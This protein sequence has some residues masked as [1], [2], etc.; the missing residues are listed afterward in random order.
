[1]R[2]VPPC[3]FEGMPVESGWRRH[4]R[5]PAGGEYAHVNNQT[6]LAF[7]GMAR[8]LPVVLTDPLCFMKGVFG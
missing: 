2:S 4:C 5:W 7:L 3:V 1:V 8:T 6:E